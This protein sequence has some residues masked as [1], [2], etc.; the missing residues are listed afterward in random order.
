VYWVKKSANPSEVAKKTVL[1][2]GGAW[3]EGH[4]DSDHI[5][6]FVPMRPIPE[7]QLQ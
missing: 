7:K 6:S 3:H 5:N 2:F 4:Q 1:G